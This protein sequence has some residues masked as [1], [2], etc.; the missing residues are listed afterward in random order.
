M[1]RV[2]TI[3]VAV[4]LALGAAV[5]TA[6]PYGY[7]M[8][9]GPGMMMG[10]GMGPGMMGQGGQGRGYGCPG[11]GWDGQGQAPAAQIDAAKAKEISQTY[12]EKAT[13]DPNTTR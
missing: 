9:G 5:V 4:G 7:C 1:K 11:I 6:Q 10:G 12:A 3:A 8:G 13:T 2:T